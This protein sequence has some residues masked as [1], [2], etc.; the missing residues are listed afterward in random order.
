MYTLLTSPA[1]FFFSHTIEFYIIIMATLPTL[2]GSGVPPHYV[3]VKRAGQTLFLHC[4]VHVDTVLTIKER[5]ELLTGK[6]VAQQRLFLGRQLLENHHT[7]YDCGIEREDEVV[8]LAYA[9]GGNPMQWEEPQ[10]AQSGQLGRQ[11]TLE[12]S[13][14]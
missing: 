10:E 3:R 8:T 7:L 4:D 11:V 14:L 5:V 9:L 2:A 6:P 1:L 12:M 13:A